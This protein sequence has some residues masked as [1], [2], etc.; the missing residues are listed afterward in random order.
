[1]TPLR[2]IMRSQSRRCAAG[3][4]VH[5]GGRGKVG[6]DQRIGQCLNLWV[7]QCFREDRG[8][9]CSS[10]QPRTCFAEHWTAARDED[11]AVRCT[12]DQVKRLQCGT[13]VARESILN[14]AVGRQ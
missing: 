7:A 9:Q 2:S 14:L 12:V 1:M 13:D 4:S 11:F 10:H 8:I 6:I 5:R 3:R